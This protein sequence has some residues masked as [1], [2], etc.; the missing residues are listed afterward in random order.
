MARTKSLNCRLV[1]GVRSI[2]KPSTRDAMNRRLFGIVLVRSH[3]ERAARNPDHVRM[4]RALR[5]PRAVRNCSIAHSLTRAEASSTLRTVAP[6]LVQKYELL[7]A[8]IDNYLCVCLAQ[9]SALE[10]S[11]PPCGGDTPRKFTFRRLSAACDTTRNEL[12]MRLAARHLGPFSVDAGNYSPQLQSIQTLMPPMLFGKARL[13][14]FAQRSTSLGDLT[15]GR[16]PPIRLSLCGDGVWRQGENGPEITGAI[17]RSS[18]CVVR[19]IAVV[20]SRRWSDRMPVARSLVSPLVAVTLA[21]AVITA[22]ADVFPS[23]TRTA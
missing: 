11:R 5:S 9:R 2:Q 8:K 1:T 6:T 7:I 18:R 3:A 19:C 13:S 21:A 20:L 16:A 4:G 10:I 22:D 12:V 23:P 14:R 15:D 17:M